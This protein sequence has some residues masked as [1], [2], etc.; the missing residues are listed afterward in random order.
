M[1]FNIPILR[2]EFLKDLYMHRTILLILVNAFFLGLLGVPNASA[3]DS[4]VRQLSESKAGLL[5]LS[6]RGGIDVGGANKGVFLMRHSNNQFLVAGSLVNGQVRI[7][8]LND[9][10]ANFR[11]VGIADLDRNGISDLIFQ[12]VTQGES[13]EV[14]IWN[15]FI[16]ASD[17]LLRSVKVVWDIQATADLDGDGFPDLVWRYNVAGSPD[18]G[19]SYIWFT[20]GTSV[21][22]VRKRGGAPLNWALLG[23]MDLNR[24]GAADMVYVSPDGAIRVLMATASRT[25]ANFSAGSI[26]GGYSALRFD[27]F[28]GRGKGDLLLRNPTTGDVRLLSLNATYVQLPPAGSNPD[29]P[30]ASCSATTEVIPAALETLPSSDRTWWLYGTADLNG[31][32]TTDIVWA[33]PAGTMVVWLLSPTG[34]APTVIANAGNIPARELYSAFPSIA[35]SVPPPTPVTTAIAVSVAGRGTGLVTSTPNGISCSVSCST[36]FNTGATVTLRALP[37]SG[38]SFVG[39]SGACAGNATCTVSLEVARSVTATFSAP[40]VAALAAPIESLFSTS[41]AN[42]S[43]PAGTIKTARSRFDLF[44][45]SPANPVMRGVT[46]TSAAG[47]IS[48]AFF[49]GGSLS[50][51]VGPDGGRVE[52]VQRTR[53]RTDYQFFSPAN[54]YTGGFAVIRSADSP[55]WSV[56]AIIG[57]SALQTNSEIAGFFGGTS[58]GSFSIFTT[59]GSELDSLQ[60]LPANVGAALEEFYKL[61]AGSVPPKAAEWQPG[62][63]EGPPKLFQQKSVFGSSSSRNASAAAGFGLAAVVGAGVC[64]AGIVVCGPSTIVLVG[65]AGL[66]MN[67]T[68]ASSAAQSIAARAG[69]Q[70]LGDSC[71]NPDAALASWCSTM[72]DDMLGVQDDPFSSLRNRVTGLVDGV[73][74]RWSNLTQSIN[75]V[76]DRFGQ[77]SLSDASRFLPFDNSQ[78]PAAGS[79]PG[80]DAGVTGLAVTQLGNVPY[81]LTG[82]MRRDR[83]VTASGAGNDGTSIQV[84]GSLSGAAF[85]GSTTISRGGVAGQP[86]ATS[87]SARPVSACN[88]VTESGG[89]GAFSR[90]YSIGAGTV[91]SFS[92][93]AYSIPD[94]FA[95]F[96]LNRSTGQWAQAFST[97]G[98]VSGRG[99]QNLSTGGSPYAAV[100]VTAPNQGTAWEFTLGCAR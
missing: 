54:V 72:Q 20:N 66:A 73:S 70:L 4:P 47:E 50:T 93:D 99:N 86:G 53:E 35:S 64:L 57:A 18:T 30:N 69:Q 25:C 80:V 38:S 5:P 9:P 89:Q 48:R 82:I 23:A 22:Q 11:L 7:D 61:N 79:L 27:D 1:V 58:A 29:D 44:V 19:V 21:T 41:V 52:V 90:T 12:I 68:G 33:T 56:G 85:T 28:T 76:Q 91:F 15:D 62:A 36:Q 100:T 75:S 97:S 37:T 78:R 71:V 84:N 39:W 59:P 49:S 87:G 88:T 55:T 3:N 6:Q 42:A 98:L 16:R 63:A 45:E 65:L 74:N 2:R 26:P 24:D 8:L 46:V 81:S 40:Q 94:A 13:G 43:Q 95:V 96:T 34:A 77:M 31:D 60:P 83:T 51:L 10:G 17:K 32:G 92:Y 67:V 14:R